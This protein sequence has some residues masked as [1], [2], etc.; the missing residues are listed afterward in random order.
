[1]QTYGREKQPKTL[2]AAIR[3]R[4]KVAGRMRVKRVMGKASFAKIEDSSG[5][6]QLFLQ[7][8]TL[9]EVIR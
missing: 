3:C 6:L 7:R 4:V 2:E 1:M 9:G 5:P 8:E